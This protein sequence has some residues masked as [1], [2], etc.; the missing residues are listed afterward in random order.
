MITLRPFVNEHCRDEIDTEVLETYSIGPMLY[1]L[2]T[3]LLIYKTFRKEQSL[4]YLCVWY[5]T[6]SLNATV[7][8]I[9]WCF[10]MQKGDNFISLKIKAS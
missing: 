2:K 7:V 8:K 4:A 5:I 9:H 1:T 6:Y 3:T 10:A